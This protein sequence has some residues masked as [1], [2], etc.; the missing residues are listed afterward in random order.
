[1]IAE[2]S[3]HRNPGATVCVTVG[4]TAPGSSHRTT[5]ADFTDARCVTVES[6]VKTFQTYEIPISRYRYVFQ[7]RYV[8]DMHYTA[9]AHLITTNIGSRS[10]GVSHRRFG[11]CVCDRW[12]LWLLVD[13]LLPSSV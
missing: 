7:G 13:G 3:S 9:L 1:M 5:A 10:T 6:I 2:S 11:S 8:P 12:I 4:T